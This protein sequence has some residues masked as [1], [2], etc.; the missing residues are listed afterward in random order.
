MGERGQRAL[1]VNFDGELKLEF[2]GTTISSDAGL[3]DLITVRFR[4]LFGQYD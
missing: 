1:R 2:H 3:T 4:G